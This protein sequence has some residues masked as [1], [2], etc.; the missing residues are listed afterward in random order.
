VRAV[1]GALTALPT[2]SSV[3]VDLDAEGVSTVR[4]EAATDLSIEQVRAALE[5]EGEFSVVG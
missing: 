5:D 2:V 3:E 4:V 1:S